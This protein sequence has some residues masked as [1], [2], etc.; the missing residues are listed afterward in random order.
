LAYSIA[1]L[2]ILTIWVNVVGSLKKQSSI[3]SGVGA[4][5]DFE[6]NTT[7]LTDQGK[8]NLLNSLFASVGV[9]NSTDIPDILVQIFHMA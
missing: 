8:A 3:K 4:L 2:L 7:I 5:L 6:S 1:L 9:N